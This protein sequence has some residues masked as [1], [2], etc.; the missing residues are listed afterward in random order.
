M[1]SFKKLKTKNCKL[2]KL[3]KIVDPRG[4]ITFL[5][6]KNHVPFDISRVYYLYDTPSGAERGGHAHYDLEQLII[7]VSGSFDVIIDDGFNSERV[8]LLR[9][10]EGLLISSMIWRELKNFSGGAVC[11]VLASNLYSESD[12]IRSY[13]EFCNTVKKN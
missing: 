11:L 5:E 13:D 7:A 10:D 12:Y 8:T 9:P 6:E 3:N 4:N 2:I 1:G